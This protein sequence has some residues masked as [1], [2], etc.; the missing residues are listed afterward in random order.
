[1][2]ARSSLKP[3]LLTAQFITKHPEIL[4]LNAL[5]KLDPLERLP[6]LPNGL[7]HII[8]GDQLHRSD[9][10][11][12]AI[13]YQTRDYTAISGLGVPKHLPQR[14]KTSMNPFC[15]LQP[16][17]LDARHGLARNMQN[18]VEAKL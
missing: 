5:V 13:I 4:R 8:R 12:D 14:F 3:Q 7:G 9:V 6:Q 1:M 10:H 16:A 11:D 17:A 2:R 18:H 15:H